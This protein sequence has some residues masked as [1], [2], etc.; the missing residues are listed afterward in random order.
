MRPT[1]K[2]DSILAGRTC[3]LLYQGTL[4]VLDSGFHFL[5]AAADG[6]TH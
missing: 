6:F 3:V 4:L 5:D 1:Q 2:P